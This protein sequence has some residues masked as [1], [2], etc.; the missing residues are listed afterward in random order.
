MKVSIII[1]C[2]FLFL[3][4][5][6]CSV[7]QALGQPIHDE[8]GMHLLGQL[9]RNIE[10]GNILL[11]HHDDLISGYRWTFDQDDNSFNKSDVKDVCGDYPA[12]FGVDLGSIEYYGLTYK[13][14]N[15][16][17]H[18]IE[19]IKAHYARGGIITISSHMRNVLT[20]GSAWDV[21][22]ENVVAKILNNDSIQRRF[23]KV[24]D[25]YAEFFNQLTD[26]M[27]NKIPI[28]YRPWHESNL[29]CF[30]W[31]GANCSD[32][33]YRDLWRLTFN[34]LTEQHGLKNLLWVYSPSNVNDNL[35]FY[36][37]YP[38]D[39]YVDIIGYEGYH[40]YQ[41]D[42]DDIEKERF[43]NKVN[44]GLNYLEVVAKR[45]QKLCAIT[46]T[47]IISTAEINWW[48]ECL[49]PCLKGRNLSYVY[50]WG[51]R[52]GDPQKVYGPYKGANCSVDFLK[53]SKEKEC[54]LLK[55]IIP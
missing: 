42:N 6:G 5:L 1:C 53:F 41:N 22:G 27:G 45:H 50:I 11:G 52:Y 9:K 55:E 51:N 36:R 35:E 48:T 8:A 37:R 13:R 31:A 17:T 26:S 33:E 4:L 28:I 24:L 18:M 10:K 21:G 40:Y 47:G 20:N 12:V 54:T 39:V 46:E 49:L 16:F 29:D 7:P 19:A 43:K 2:F 15:T 30:W 44:K 34:Y 3:V 32:S 25:L 14:G 38:G 23:F